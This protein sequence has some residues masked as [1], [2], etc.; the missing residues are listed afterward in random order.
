[1]DVGPLP[2]IIDFVGL[3]DLLPARLPG[4]LVL[5]PIVDLAFAAPVLAVVLAESIILLKK[6]LRF[7]C[8]E[9][10]P[11]STPADSIG[12]RFQSAVGVKGLF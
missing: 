5:L 8:G 4:R 6:P 1:M 3:P 10:K 11:P 7:D 2:P 12:S 9:L